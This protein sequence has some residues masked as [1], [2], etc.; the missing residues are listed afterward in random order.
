MEDHIEKPEKTDHDIA[1]EMLESRLSRSALGSSEIERIAVQLLA[2]ALP[3]GSDRILEIRKRITK[4][5]CDGGY[6]EFRQRR[7][8]RGRLVLID[9]ASS[10]DEKDTIGT[11]GRLSKA[12]LKQQVSIER[13]RSLS[14]DLV[15]HAI[16]SASPK[17]RQFLLSAL[18][19]V[20]EGDSIGEIARKTGL[21]P[22]QIQRAFDG[23]RQA[24]ANP[25]RRIKRSV[26]ENGRRSAQFNPRRV[27]MELC[28]QVH[29]GPVIWDFAPSKVTRRARNSARQTDI[30]ELPHPRNATR[31]EH[32]VFGRGLILRKRTLDSGE[33]LDIEFDDGSRRTILTSWAP[34]S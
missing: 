32:P 7:I 31:I 34:S 25:A 22:A 16:K 5:L 9:D 12:N 13:E 11:D 21:Y 6:S 18:S 2:E 1:V 14:R 20:E 15:D 17:N 26:P 27:R 3:N 28:R 10:M 29:Q 8:S 33:C 23:A 19:E 30:S 4:W 24:T